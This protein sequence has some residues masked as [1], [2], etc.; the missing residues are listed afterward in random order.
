M[1][2]ELVRVISFFLGLLS[3]YPAIW[4]AFFVPGARW[5]D[6]LEMALARIFTS[7]CLCLASGFLFAIPTQENA[8][9]PISVLNTLPVRV[10]LFA[11]A[12]MAVMFVASWSLEEYYIPLTYKNQPW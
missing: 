6:R 3:L 4:S 12:G 11:L 10:F 9:E 1:L 8:E 2:L 5:E 7:A